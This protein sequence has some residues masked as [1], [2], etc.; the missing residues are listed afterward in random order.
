MA[1]MS[2]K[3]VG[4]C[5]GI[6]RLRTLVEYHG[7]VTVDQDPAF[8]VPVD[9]LGEDS[10]LQ[11]AALANQV[12]DTVAVRHAGDVLVDDRTFIQIARRVVRRG[13]DEFHAALVGLMIRTSA[14]KRR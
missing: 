12:L 9:G 11:V 7:L 5:R 2:A 6:V 13:A 8:E 14:S 3:T 10:F 4:S 1:R